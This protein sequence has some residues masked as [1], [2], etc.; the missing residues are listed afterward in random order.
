M[1]FRRAGGEP[2]AGPGRLEHRHHHLRGPARGLDGSP[3]P[4][5]RA[6][7][8]HQRL[9]RVPGRAD[10]ARVCGRADRRHLD[11][12][13]SRRDRRSADP[14]R[15]GAGRRFVAR[16]GAVA[17]LYAD[18]ACCRRGHHVDVDPRAGGLMAPGR[19]RADR[20]HRDGPPR[21][22]QVPA[23]HP[24]ER[25]GAPAATSARPGGGGAPLGR[26]DRHLH[27]VDG[28]GPG[29]RIGPRPP[30]A[31][32]GRDAGEHGVGHRSLCRVAG[33]PRRERSTW[34]SA[35]APKGPSF[36]PSMRGG[37]TGTALGGSSA[38]SRPP[39]RDQQG[40][41]APH[42]APRVHLYQFGCRG[43]AAGCAGSGLPR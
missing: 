34:P 36:W 16:A 12:R 1:G 5:G 10:H 6:A 14:V 8:T 7:G 15:A 43:P 25:P 28:P 30:D 37:W 18:L 23:E 41:R 42:A 3:G 11:R 39:R 22:R 21:T 17:W 31:R 29:G 13:G 20:H 26:A 38:R 40:G 2:G 9:A 27:P 19:G 35:S 24:V 4:A 33:L 32:S